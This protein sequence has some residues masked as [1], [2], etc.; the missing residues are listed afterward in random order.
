MVPLPEVTKVN[1]PLVVHVSVLAEQDAY[2]ILSEGE[3]PHNSRVYWFVVDGWNRKASAI[4]ACPQG[5]PSSGF[6]EDP[7]ATTL[8]RYHVIIYKPS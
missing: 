4:R 6:P 3:D 5:V 2:I 8:K 1:G 7:C